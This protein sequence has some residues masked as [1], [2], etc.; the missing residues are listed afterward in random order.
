M[1]KPFINVDRNWTRFVWWTKRLFGRPI[2]T[3]DRP[4]R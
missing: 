3:N 2:F 1:K 4:K